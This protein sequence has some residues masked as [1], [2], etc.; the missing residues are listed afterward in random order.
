MDAPFC[1]PLENLSIFSWL[2]LTSAW[3][4]VISYFW[5][6]HS[7]I[8]RCYFWNSYLFLS[9][10]KICARHFHLKNCWTVQVREFMYIEITSPELYFSSHLGESFIF[11]PFLLILGED[12]PL[13]QCLQVYSSPRMYQESGNSNDIQVQGCHGFP[14]WDCH[15]GVRMWPRDPQHQDLGNPC[16][17]SQ[18]LPS[19]V[20]CDFVSPRICKS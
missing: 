7:P 3:R 10:L 1:R 9:Y 8:T 5:S 18:Q 19:W 15:T 12:E 2:H 20:T 4:G 17:T 6:W 13:K 14:M 11:L 16:M